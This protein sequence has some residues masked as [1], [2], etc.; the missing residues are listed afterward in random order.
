MI[1]RLS[2]KFLSKMLELM[3]KNVIKM[4][5]IMFLNT[6]PPKYSE[7]SMMSEPAKFFINL[8]TT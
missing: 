1:F 4:M 6:F 5:P 2:Q 3:R 7:M 8:T